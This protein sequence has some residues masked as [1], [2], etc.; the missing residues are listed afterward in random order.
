MPWIFL[1]IYFL[2]QG[3]F[4]FV[5]VNDNEENITIFFTDALQCVQKTVR[6]TESL[7]H[8]TAI[9]DRFISELD[10]YIQTISTDQQFEEGDNLGSFDALE[11]LHACQHVINSHQDHKLES[12]GGHCTITDY[13]LFPPQQ[14]LMR[15]CV[16]SLE[17]SFKSLQVQDKGPFKPSI[18]QNQNTAVVCETLPPTS[19]PNWSN[20]RVAQYMLERRGLNKGSVITGHCSKPEDWAV[21]GRVKQ[22]CLFLL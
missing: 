19:W 11:A 5:R 20:T 2:F 15:P 1:L 13:K 22:S 6:E 12:T 16:T 10:G 21:V 8:D 9:L 4:L 7:G 14:C 3:Q 18:T 17:R